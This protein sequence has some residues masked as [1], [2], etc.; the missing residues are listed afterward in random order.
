MTKG[1]QETYNARDTQYG[2][3]HAPQKDTSSRQYG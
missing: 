3:G 2:I 1:R